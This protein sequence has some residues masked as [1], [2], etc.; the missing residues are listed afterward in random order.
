MPNKDI[1]KKNIII[2]KHLVKE[3]GKKVSGNNLTT[4][5][6]RLKN[7][8][9]LT[10]EEEKALAWL[11]KTYNKKKEVSYHNK[12]I[13]RKNGRQNAFKKTHTKDNKN[14]NVSKVGGLAKLT[15][16][17]EHSKVSKQLEDNMVQ[18]YESFNKEI[19]SMV[20]LIEYMDNN[21]NKIT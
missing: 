20:Y 11:T 13:Q 8:E 7:K 3:L 2:P 4:K 10:N 17:G 16:S 5:I 14:I 9:S 19:N 18:Y 21:K 6:S 12:D 1:N 15:S